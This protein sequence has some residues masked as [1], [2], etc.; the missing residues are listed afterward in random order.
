M[1]LVRGRNPMAEPPTPGDIAKL[2]NPRHSQTPLF[3]VEGDSPENVSWKAREVGEEEE[4]A[5]S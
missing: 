3:G 5:S 2:D 1:S 4:N